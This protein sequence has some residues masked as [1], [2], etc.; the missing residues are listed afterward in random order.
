MDDSAK[1][2]LARCAHSDD[3]TTWRSFE[4]FFKPRLLAGITRTLW[5]SHQRTDPDMVDELLQET[6][7]R[8]LAGERRILKAFAGDTEGAACVYLMRVAESVTLDRLRRGA[9][10]KRGSEFSLIRGRTAESLANRIRDPG[11]SPEAQA[12]R[13]DL[14][15]RFWKRCEHLSGSRDA[16]RDL[17]ILDLALF[18]GWTSREI[19]VA[20]GLRPSTVD[21]VIHRLRR[22]LERHGLNLPARTRAAH[23][24]AEPATEAD[25]WQCGN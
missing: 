12:V 19:A 8:L 25:G 6:W 3:P 21:T 18:Q 16:D 24:V 13:K 20:K 22:R 4:K 23:E 7:C 10:T 17:E 5:R 2:L 15:K 1:A 11:A 14:W 9:A